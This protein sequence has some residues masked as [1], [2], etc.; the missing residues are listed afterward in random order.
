MTLKKILRCDI[1]NNRSKGGDMNNCHANAPQLPNRKWAYFPGSH[2]LQAWASEVRAAVTAGSPNTAVW[3]MAG[4]AIVIELP[5]ADDTNLLLE[6]LSAALGFGY[7]V[8]IPGVREVAE[9]PEGPAGLPRLLYVPPGEWQACAQLPEFHPVAGDILSR[10]GL[11]DPDS[12]EI[13]VTTV[14]SFDRFAPSLLGTGRFSRA[15]RVVEATA[16]EYGRLFLDAVGSSVLSGDLQDQSARIG[17]LLKLNHS[18]ITAL[19][20]S[21]L[22]VQRGLAGTGRRAEWRDLINLSLQGLI[23]SG[24]AVANAGSDLESVA[25]HEAGHAL[26][27]YL[28]SAGANLPELVTITPTSDYAGV[29]FGSVE[30]HRFASE[31]MRYSDFRH[32]IRVALA[33]RAAEELAYG[34]EGISA[35]CSSDLESASRLTHVAF[36]R[37]GFSPDMDLSGTST[38]NLFT[39]IGDHTDSEF[40][41]VESLCR[42]FLENQYRHVLQQ[43]TLHRQSLA[44]I[45]NALLAEMALDTPAVL[46]LLP[47]LQA[48]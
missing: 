33:G 34:P 47:P 13:V 17:H 43:L 22:K 24:P 39:V 44:D 10:I 37:W 8:W 19:Q 29:M 1:A 26:M 18:S 40:Q 35:G 7:E 15:L 30:F 20:M 41:H 25:W 38:R 31:R 23:D 36:S 4:T 27:A 46:R 42:D 14:A 28:D 11:F 16:E 2:A 9:C 12:P 6:A 48:A 32:K 45:K 5:D 21:A 3:T